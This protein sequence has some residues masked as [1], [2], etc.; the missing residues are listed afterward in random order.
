MSHPTTT[1]RRRVLAS[2][3]AAVTLTVGMSST[4]TT[5][6][7]TENPTD[8][9]DLPGGFHDTRALPT[10][11]AAGDLLR[12]E[13]AGLP[14][15]ISVPGLPAL[16]S[17]LPAV[18]RRV[19]YR[20][21]DVDQQ[22]VATSGAFYDSTAPWSGPGP[23]PTMILGPGTQ[24]QG[25]PCAPSRT[26][27]SG[28]GANPRSGAPIVSYEEGFAIALAAQG[29][30]VMVIDYIGLG[31]PGIHTYAD[32]VEQAHA[33]L[34][35]ARAA[36][37]LIGHDSPL[38]LWGHSQGGGASAAAA[39]LAPEYAPE[40][41]LRAAYASAPPADLLAVLDHIDGSSL[42][43]AIGFAINGMAE[44]YPAVR[45][46]V[47]EHVSPAG[48]RA[49]DDLSGLC[50]ADTRAAYGGR[51]TSEWTN[52]GRNLGEL[53]RDEPGALRV[54]DHQRI[55]NRTPTVP[56]MIAGGINDDIIPLGQVQQ[57]GRDWCA[58][59]VDVHFRYETTPLVPGITHAAA[60]VTNFAPAVQYLRDRLAGLPAPNDCGA[61]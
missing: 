27:E 30:R 17:P 39:E 34:D 1:I 43:G 45:E 42:T 13:P 16:P 51:A 25:D 53:I 9:F 61:L 4:A 54:L 22:P 11:G 57:L 32:R 36:Q 24:G 8:T 6:A 14:L 47:E 21:V 52:S 20:T 49:L 19:I 56:V 28:V 31:T 18:A 10:Q 50:L 46:V 15:A 60:A 26:V 37:N 5:A 29:F 38:V 58:Q 44:R 41:D 48:R 2:L 7:A 59:G 55:G 40:L 3:A 35:G 33:M 12:T 23:R